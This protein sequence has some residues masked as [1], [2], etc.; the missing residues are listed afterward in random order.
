MNVKKYGNPVLREM[1]EPINEVTAD[2]RKLAD[3]MVETMYDENGIGLAAPQVGV[4][5]RMFTIDVNFEENPVYNTPGE[6]LLCPQMPLALINPE[7]TATYGDSVEFMEGCLSVPEINA[8]VYR[9]DRIQ[10]KA[11]ILDGDM[12][13]LECGGLLSRCVQHEIDHLDGVLF[14]DRAEEEDL[15]KVAAKLKK[16]ENKTKKK[17]NSRRR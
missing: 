8:T 4:N 10:L 16:L 12:I 9:P 5:L 14:T 7:I 15:K 6:A 2:I 13:D 3:Q 1:C 11:Q 17:L